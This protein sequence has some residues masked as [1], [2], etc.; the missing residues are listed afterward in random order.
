MARNLQ[1]P[2]TSKRL[3]PYK[4]LA[5]NWKGKKKAGQSRNQRLEKTDSTCS[6]LVKKKARSS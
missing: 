1:L 6:V 3:S 4:Q 5:H 2:A